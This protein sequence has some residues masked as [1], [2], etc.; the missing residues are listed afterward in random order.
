[1]GTIE[2]VRQ[3]EPHHGESVG[4]IAIGLLA[5]GAVFAIAGELLN[6]CSPPCRQ[7]GERA[8]VAASETPHLMSVDQKEESCRT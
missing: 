4:G 8:L 7:R 2:R 5:A 6:G 1:M 3:R